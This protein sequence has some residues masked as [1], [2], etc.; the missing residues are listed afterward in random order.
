VDGAGQGGGSLLC[1][2]QHLDR[3]GRDHS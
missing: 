3:E 2:P 1:C